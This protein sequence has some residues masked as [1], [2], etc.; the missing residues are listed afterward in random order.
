MDIDV[1]GQ[2]ATPPFKL[3]IDTG[4]PGTPAARLRTASCAP[5]VDCFAARA[6]HPVGQDRRMH[7]AGSADLVFAEAGGSPGFNPPPEKPFDPR[8]G[9]LTV[10]PRALRVSCGWEGSMP[11]EA[12]SR[13]RARSR[14][15]TRPHRPRRQRWRCWA[16]AGACATAA[17]TGARSTS[18]RWPPCR[19]TPSST[20]APTAP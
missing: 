5:C 13:A 3:V 15:T 7:A 9:G 11:A 14:P 20:G 2:A 19:S 16:M 1:A 8:A 17:S 10:R 12:D 18:A 4:A 6:V